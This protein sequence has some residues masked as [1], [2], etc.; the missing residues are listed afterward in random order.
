MGFRKLPSRPA[1][2]ASFVVHG[3]KAR[4]TGKGTITGTLSQYGMASLQ[5]RWVRHRLK[6]ELP[7][8]LLLLSSLLSAGVAL[9]QAL[10]YT[11]DACHQSVSKGYLQALHNGV[12]NGQAL[13]SVGSNVLPA[14]L[15]VMMRT[16]ELTGELPRILSSWAVQTLEQQ[17]WIEDL[18]KKAAYP[19]LLLLG[20]SLTMMVISTLVIP[21]FE[22]M[23]LE[24]G[25]SV[26]TGTRTM[27]A[28]MH[29]IPASLVIVVVGILLGAAVVHIPR[30]ASSQAWKQ[31]KNH[32]PGHRLIVLHRTQR[33]C[34][35][36]ALLIDAGLPLLDA[37][38][39]MAEVHRQPWIA[40]ASRQVAERV[41]AGAPLSRCFEGEWDRLLALQIQRAEISGD[42][43]DALLKTESVTREEFNRRIERIRTWLEP[44]L[45]IAVGV[46]VGVTM[47]SLYVPMYTLISDIS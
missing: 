26:P 37:L 38:I 6:A 17:R 8:L 43:A 32:L 44:V 40:T 41:A 2:L 20:T 24:M 27:M 13:S 3:V 22:H 36:L 33:F 19:L 1:F 14:W 42:L 16:A 46:L 47:Y 4:R 35:T 31:C 23:Y 15:L 34:L 28:V 21:Q 5:Q 18:R 11:S 12:Q 10:S 45:S 29:R 39:S 30:V 25:K 7:E 9:E